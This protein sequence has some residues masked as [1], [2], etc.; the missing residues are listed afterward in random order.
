MTGDVLLCCAAGQLAAT[1]IRTWDA[2]PAET[3]APTFANAARQLFAVSP[4]ITEVTLL[5]TRATL[6][7]IVG[8]RHGQHFDASAQ[9]VT[10]KEGTA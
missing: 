8:T 9:P 7:F 10:I 4:A 1:V 3:A 6:L 2:P 5:S